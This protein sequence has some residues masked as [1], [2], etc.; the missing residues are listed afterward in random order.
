M[1][2]ILSFTSKVLQAIY[3]DLKLFR[4]KGNSAFPFGFNSQSLS[5]AAD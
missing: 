3:E 2:P 1:Q 5:A 4:I